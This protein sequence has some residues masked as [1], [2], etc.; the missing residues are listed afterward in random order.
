[1]TPVPPREN[2]EHGYSGGIN[3]LEALLA[4]LKK[5]EPE[6]VVR[7]ETS[8]RRQTQAG[9]FVVRRAHDPRLTPMG[10]SWLRLRDLRGLHRWHEVLLEPADGR[11]FESTRRYGQSPLIDRIR[12]AS[13]VPPTVIGTVLRV[14]DASQR[15]PCRTDRWPLQ[16]PAVT[17][18]LRHR[19]CSPATGDLQTEFDT[20]AA[21]SARYSAKVAASAR[22]LI[23]NDKSLALS[24]PITP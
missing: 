7:F 22:D 6:G 20:R 16:G 19:G 1:V 4:P 18:Q 13:A 21:A 3:R 5:A 17:A 2:R 9:F 23:E 15:Q 8:R 24:E 11:G 12:N 10:D 14:V